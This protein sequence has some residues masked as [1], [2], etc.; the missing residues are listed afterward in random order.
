MRWLWRELTRP[1]GHTTHR[2]YRGGRGSRGGV[3]LLLV[4]SNLLL[5]SVLVSEMTYTASVRVKL[6]VHERDEAKAE[7]LGQDRHHHDP[8]A[9]PEQPGDEAGNH[10]TAGQHRGKKQNVRE[11]DI[12]KHGTVLGPKSAAGRPGR[13]TCGKR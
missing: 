7:Q 3:A 1:R 5:M 11:R 6:A 10:G 4:L 12:K 2:F 9:D 8:A 13:A